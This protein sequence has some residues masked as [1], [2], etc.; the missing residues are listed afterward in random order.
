VPLDPA[1]RQ[2]IKQGA[3]TPAGEVERIAACDDAVVLL[4]KIGDL[5]RDDK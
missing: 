1:Q 3:V 4:R 5:E 2:Q